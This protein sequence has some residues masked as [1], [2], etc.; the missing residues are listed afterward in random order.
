[1]GV[2]LTLS[3]TTSLMGKRCGRVGMS[4]CIILSLPTA[5][6]TEKLIPFK[7]G[8]RFS[9]VVWQKIQGHTGWQCDTLNMILMCYQQVSSLVTA[10]Y[11][12]LLSLLVIPFDCDKLHERLDLDGGCGE[13]PRI[14]FMVLS[15]VALL[16]F[17]PFALLMS[18][19][20]FDY[21]NLGQPAN[22]FSRSTGRVA[23]ID[24][25]ARYA[26]QDPG[27]CHV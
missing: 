3:N 8:I 20:Y 27:V 22:W 11:I 10:G 16:L 13:W 15:G 21:H 12:P 1:M 24:T 4:V 26:A 23:F 19:V 2:T 18:L 14:L 25:V 17:V 6:H 7:T 5:G 9:R